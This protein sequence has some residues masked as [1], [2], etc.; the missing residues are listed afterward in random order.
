MKLVRFGPVGQEK[1]GIIDRDGNIRSLADHVADIS[2]PFLSNESLAM[3][4]ALS[5]NDLPVIEGNPR[6]GACVGDIGKVMCIGLNFTDHAKETGSTPPAEPILF[7]KATS[8]VVGPYDNIELPRGSQKTDWEVELAVVIGKAAK[9]VSEDKAM[10]Y[11][12]GFACMNDVSERAFQAEGTGQ[13]TKGKSCDTFGPLGPWM[14]TKDEVGNFNDLHMRLDVNGQRMQ[15]GNSSNMIFNV[16]QIISY[17]SQ[18]FTLQPGDVIS[19][20]TPAGV[21]LG[22]S[23]EVFLRP[24]DTVTMG[25]DKLGEQSN[26]VVQG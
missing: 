18:M 22:M 17:L 8:A 21:G 3:V 9:Y 24:G 7:M 6:Y 25:I 12:A 14:V 13:W 5:L 2:G 1:P 15:D 20:G 4:A 23:P 11:V 19:T 10:D 16:P 26:T